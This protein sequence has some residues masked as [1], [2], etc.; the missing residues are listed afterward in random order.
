MATAYERAGAGPAM[1]GPLAHAGAEARS[2][3]AVY[4]LTVA[5]LVIAVLLGGGGANPP[6]FELFIEVASIPLLGAVVLQFDRS[7]VRGPALAGIVLLACF[8]AIPLAQLVPLPASVWIALPGRGFA[9]EAA[10][11]GGF[12]GQ[13]MPLSL[14]REATL[15][16]AMALLPGAVMFVAVLHLAGDQRWRLAQTLLGLITVSAVLGAVQVA[17]GDDPA[18]LLY[19]SQHVGYPIGLFANRNHQ[20]DLL[21]IGVALAGG[22]LAA[23]EPARRSRL[24]PPLFYGLM[25]L[26]VVEVVATSSR[27]GI[28]LLVPTLLFVFYSLIVRTA[29]T[30]PGRGL[31]LALIAVPFVLLVAGGSVLERATQRF[32]R[33]HD[34]RLDFWPDV[35]WAI[36]QYFPAGSGMGTFD[37]VFR[38]AERLAIVGPHY[39]N[40]AHNDY[41]E[42]VL[43]AGLPGLVA[44]FAF[45]VWLAIAAYRG[46]RPGPAGRPDMLRRFALVSIAV[47]VLHS[48]VDY[49]LRQMSLETIFAFCCA[50][51][52]ARG[53]GSPPLR[54]P[55]AKRRSIRILRLVEP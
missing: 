54:A 38:S 25:A 18:M 45:F 29:A 37:T 33:L 10:R 1:T 46:W 39:V 14:D 16:S 48:T 36:D 40:H 11:L 8:A 2:S 6:L 51:L 15:R 49:P 35:R 23:D 20:A 4:R 24:Q 9:L 19:T 27:M 12:A 41:L 43:E 47:I 42:V 31:R 52:V 34:F 7:R 13:A 30:L 21:L 5:L 26:F 28:M 32:D 50:L 55:G 17:A 53:E 3:V 22:L 44:L